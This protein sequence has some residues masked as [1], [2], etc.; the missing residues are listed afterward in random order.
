M[1]RENPA[2]GE[3]PSGALGLRAYF[4]ASLWTVEARHQL[5]YFLSSIL[6]STSFLF[7]ELQ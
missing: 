3:V 5:Q 4:L 7:F 1:Q 6:R 2:F